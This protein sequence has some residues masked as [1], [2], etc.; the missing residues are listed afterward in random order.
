MFMPELNL[1]L[2][3]GS[4][5]YN[6]LTFRLTLRDSSLSEISS[7]KR[8]EDFALTKSIPW[9][10]AEFYY[11]RG[12]WRP[13]TR[14]CIIVRE[15]INRFPYPLNVFLKSKADQLNLKDMIELNRNLG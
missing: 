4:K 1:F 2:F 11:N 7:H 15:T 10:S 3:S 8:W 5:H 14:A 13:H 12:L 6:F 9:R